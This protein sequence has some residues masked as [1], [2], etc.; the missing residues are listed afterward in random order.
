MVSNEEQLL[1]NQVKKEMI[2]LQVK[3]SVKQKHQLTC[4]HTQDVTLEY[5]AL[6]VLPAHIE[7]DE[8]QQ[9]IVVDTWTGRAKEYQ[10]L[11]KNIIIEV[12]GAK[13]ITILKALPR[14]EK[15]KLAE[16]KNVGQSS[17]PFQL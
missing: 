2:E 7:K 6:A 4:T 5:Y 15:E 1:R 14:A 10:Y 3:E 17:S 12:K 11:E 8:Q 16:K 9:V 13:T